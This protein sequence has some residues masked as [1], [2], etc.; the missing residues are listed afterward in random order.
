MTPED[1][2]NIAAGTQSLLIAIAALAG[3]LWAVYRFRSLRES[4]RAQT[5][6]LVKERELRQVALLNVELEVTVTGA[7][8][9]IGKCAL[10]KVVVTNPGNHPEVI[11][12]TKSDFLLHQVVHEAPGRIRF[13]DTDSNILNSPDKLHKSSIRP[14]ERVAFAFAV[15][16]SPGL[17]RAELAFTA[18]A[19]R[20]ELE[21]IHA[22][23]RTP[24][25]E[26]VYGAELSS[27]RFI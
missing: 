20:A 17:Y 23:G 4:S 18:I 10:I 15:S 14:S 9:D 11:D 25:G 24:G 13:D 6:L 22:E 1:F 19:S 26:L 16:L 7:I 21:V 3:G 27:V 5:E 8:G 2:K 12:W